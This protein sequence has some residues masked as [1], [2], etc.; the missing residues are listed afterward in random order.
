MVGR[1]A[2]VASTTYDGHPDSSRALFGDATV[3]AFE[4]CALS[5][6]DVDAVRPAGVGR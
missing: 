6:G 1:I 5:P 4:G 3:A 2:G